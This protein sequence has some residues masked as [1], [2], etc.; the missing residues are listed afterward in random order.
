M[1]KKSNICHPCHWKKKK[2]S[3]VWLLYSLLPHKNNQQDTH[4]VPNRQILCVYHSNFTHLV[5]FSLPSLLDVAIS[6]LRSYSNILSLSDI[7][8][9]CSRVNW[10]LPLSVILPSHHHV[11]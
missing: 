10:S 7:S 11:L 6:S 4:N 5:L 8:P 3:K 2:I 1:K 9:S